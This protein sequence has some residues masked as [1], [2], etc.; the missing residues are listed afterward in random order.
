MWKCCYGV[1][2]YIHI[3]AMAWKMKCCLFPIYVEVLSY[4][5]V[6]MLKCKYVEV[7]SI[8]VSKNEVLSVI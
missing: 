6:E 5:S 8:E 1:S 7:L 3:V 2:C 4:R